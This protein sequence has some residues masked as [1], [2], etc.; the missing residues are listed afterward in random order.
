MNHTRRVAIGILLTGAAT[1]LNGQEKQTDTSMWDS[2]PNWNTPTLGGSQFWTDHHW[3]RGW[4]IQENALTHHWRLID[5]NNI[6]HAWGSRE[7]C[8]VEL[9]AKVPDSSLPMSSAVMYLHG[10]MRTA[11]SMSSI[12][13]YV[14]EHADL[15]AI[16]FEYASTRRPISEHAIALREVLNSLPENLR[17]SFVGHSMGNIVLR[18]LIGDLQAAQDDAMLRRFDRVVMLGPPNQGASIARQLAKTEL[19]GFVTGKGGLELG[20]GWEEF[21]SKLAIPHCEFGIVA[22]N[23]HNSRVQNPL[24][25]GDSDFVVTVEETMLEGAKELIEVPQ[26]HSFLMDD[27]VV[28]SS[29]TSFLTSGRF[30]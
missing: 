3:R 10:L 5:A 19:Y 8:E 15:P 17:L 4:R 25:E 13:E 23:M 9:Y 26:L 24:I 20:P 1:R 2:L 18:H 12:G 30:H 27:P 29:V 28:Q 14:H 11:R 22:G 7:A 6:R 21:A 16:F